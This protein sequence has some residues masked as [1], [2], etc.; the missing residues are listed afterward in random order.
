MTFS[1]QKKYL[2]SLG[3]WLNGLTLNGK[4]SRA[5]TRFI[6]ILQASLTQVEKDRKAI[7][8]EYAEK[9]ENGELKVV[10]DPSGNKNYNVPEDKKAEFDKEVSDLYDEDA[11]LSG[12]EFGSIAL[13]IKDIVLNYN[14]DIEPGIA[15]MYDKWCSAFEKFPPVSGME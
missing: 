8:D 11:E 14:K 2:L 1:I 10:E 9:D 5:R 4:Q 15:V 3:N 12:P 13:V 6:D 7:L